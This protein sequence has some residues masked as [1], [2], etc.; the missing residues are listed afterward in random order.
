MK[1]IKSIKDLKKKETLRDKRRKQIEIEE[2]DD[3]YNTRL[4]R[5]DF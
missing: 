3:G 5:W 4:G 1:P 2:L